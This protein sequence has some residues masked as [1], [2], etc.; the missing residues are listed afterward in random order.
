MAEGAHNSKNAAGQ[1]GSGMAALTVPGQVTG[2]LPVGLRVVGQDQ[3]NKPAVNPGTPRGSC[4]LS[5]TMNLP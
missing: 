5:D 1:P 4:N 3:E 2:W